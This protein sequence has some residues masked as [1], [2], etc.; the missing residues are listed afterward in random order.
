M[1]ETASKYTERQRGIIERTLE[2]ENQDE[3]KYLQD[4]G[5]DILP[6][7]RPVHPAQKLSTGKKLPDVDTSDQDWTNH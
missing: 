6:S 3:W 5:N 7:V 1:S 4:H 2:P